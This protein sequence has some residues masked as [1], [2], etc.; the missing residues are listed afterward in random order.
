MNLTQKP[1]GLGGFSQF[2]DIEGEKLVKRG[3]Q[4]QLN[5]GKVGA[6]LLLMPL[7]WGFEASPETCVFRNIELLDAD[8]SPSLVFKCFFCF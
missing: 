7:N 1:S 6:V 3:Y 4:P 8:I 5:L 2:C